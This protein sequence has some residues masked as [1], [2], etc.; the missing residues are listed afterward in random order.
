MANRP[1]RGVAN[2]FTSCT[3]EGPSCYHA[4]R[5][6]PDENNTQ[7][8][9][10]RSNAAS[11]IIVE[12]DPVVALTLR[13]TLESAGYQVAEVLAAAGDVLSACVR[14]HP[15]LLLVDIML[16][17]G[18][19]IHLVEKLREAVAKMA[20]VFVS[21]KTDRE[22]FARAA[23]VAP[24]GY[25][26]KPFTPAQLL[27]AVDIALGASQQQGAPIS[28]ADVVGIERL[29]PREK[30]ILGRLMDHRRPPTI[31]QELH[32]SPHTVR[33]HLKSI[34]AK[35]GVGSQQELLD[36]VFRRQ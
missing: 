36:R 34:Y 5:V 12:D 6:Q 18:D 15:D 13:R 25:V 17:D 14:H 33:N 11:I 19:G 26:V 23:E 21:G 8:E 32:L 29:S 28:L 31:A 16:A 35:L 2:L 1:P 3:H 10:S 22:T 30:E 4:G 24:E 7:S 20:V 27:A 9:T